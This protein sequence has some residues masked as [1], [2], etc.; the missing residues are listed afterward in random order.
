MAVMSKKRRKIIC[1]GKSYIWYVCRD[2]AYCDELILHI[3]SDDKKLILSCPLRAEN[4]YIISEGTCFQG[5]ASDGCRKRY[6]MPMKPPAAVT[7][8]FVAECIIWAVQG[9]HAAAVD[10]NGEDI[11]F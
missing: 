6:L 4:A 3:I 2:E 9:S 8:R 1:G 5:R 7:P 11:R 10:Y